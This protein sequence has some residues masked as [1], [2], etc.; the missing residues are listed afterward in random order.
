MKPILTLACFISPLLVLAQQPEADSVNTIKTGFYLSV[1]SAGAT[2]SIDDL[3][4]QLRAAGQLPVTEGLVGG[5]IGITN[6]FADQNSYSVSRLSMLATTDEE[7]NSNQ[8]TRLIVGEIVVSG[9]YDVITN[10]HWLLYPYLGFGISYGR[11]TVSSIVPN[12][13]F[14]NS[15]R[16]PGDDEIAQ[17]K[18]GTDGL[19]IFGELGGGVERV[20][21]LPGLD[22]YLGISGGY[23]LSND[24][25]WTLNGVKTFYDTSF[26]TRG[27]TFEFKFRFESNPASGQSASRGL[28]EFFK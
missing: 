9:H 24:R 27:W 2:S 14:Q 25:S 17:K 23:R 13:R 20:L 15:L 22:L 11:L 8:K 21:K 28:F 7:A 4:A 19:M 1:A 5:S 18:Y 26:D 3:N 6:R 10:P 16:N 12:N